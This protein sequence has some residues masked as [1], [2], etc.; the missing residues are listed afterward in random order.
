[1]FTSLLNRPRRD[2]PRG[3]DREFSISPSSRHL[4][5]Q[6]SSRTH[7]TADFTEADDD[8][9]EDDDDD[10]NGEGASRFDN[11]AD[12]QDNDAIDD[13]DEQDQGASLPVLPLFSSTHLGMQYTPLTVT[14]IHGL[15]AFFLGWDRHSTSI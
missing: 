9:D 5:R 12:G 15:T 4:R 8:D 6:F 7:A 13:D 11:G 10:F 14:S 1:M 2:R 3:N